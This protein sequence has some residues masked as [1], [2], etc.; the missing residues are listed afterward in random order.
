M[1]NRLIMITRKIIRNYVELYPMK[2]VILYYK[3]IKIE[4]PKAFLKSQ[5][6]LCLR[7][8]LKGRIIISW[9]GLNGTLSG[10]KSSVEAY[11][12]AL[13]EDI[14]FSDIVFKESDVSGDIF[15]KLS[16]KI[17]DEIVTL[18]EK[19][20]IVSKESKKGKYISPGDFHNIV[21]NKDHDTVILDAR[22]NYESLIGRFRG[23]VTPDIDNFRDLPK[24]LKNLRKYKNKKVVM[25]CTGGVRCEKASALLLQNGFKDVYQLKDGILNYAKYHPEDF[26]G[27][28]YVFDKRI[29]VLLDKDNVKI[30]SRCKHC[31]TTSDIYINCA[32]KKCNMQFI[33]CKSCIE[34]FNRTCSMD[35]K[36]F[37]NISA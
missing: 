30:I 15:P 19:I 10:S 24:Y 20:D 34:E 7:L 27:K 33:S 35:C 28:C 1:K 6:K 18:K 26:E 23:A 9:E 14:R 12:K 32:N 25:Y 4:N 29:A 17:R 36:S 3:Y 8:N 13:L 37:I 11:K 31:G 2:R 21:V 16:I 22:N 5:K